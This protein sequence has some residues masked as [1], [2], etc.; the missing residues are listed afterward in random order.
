M[1][2]TLLRHG[3]RFPWHSRW[4]AVGSLRQRRVDVF[5]LPDGREWCFRRLTTATAFLFGWLVS[6]RITV[7]VCVPRSKRCKMFKQTSTLH[8]FCLPGELST[9]TTVLMHSTRSARHEKHHSGPSAKRLFDRILRGLSTTM[10]RQRA[11]SWVGTLAPSARRLL[12]RPGR[13]CP[14]PRKCPCHSTSTWPYRQ[15]LPKLHLGDCRANTLLGNCGVQ[16]HTSIPYPESL[17]ASIYH[18]DDRTEQ[19]ITPT[20]PTKT[21]PCGLCR[22]EAVGRTDD[23]HPTQKVPV[24]QY[25]NTLH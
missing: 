11:L 2:C 8:L 19:T 13:R 21:V 15:S 24:G 10:L 6:S 17:V 4:H 9:R 16:Q 14:L 1:E 25:T 5:P 12:G 3:I 7:F 23:L 20:I 22:S 18:F